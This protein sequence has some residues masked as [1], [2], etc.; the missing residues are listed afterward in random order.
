[1]GPNLLRKSRKSEER[2]LTGDSNKNSREGSSNRDLRWSRAPQ[3]ATEHDPC[4]H[5][6]S[7]TPTN[8]KERLFSSSERS[9]NLEVLTEKDGALDLRKI[10]RNA[11]VLQTK[12]RG[13][14]E[15]QG[16]QMGT[17]LGFKR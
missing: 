13:R 9:R 12:E 17:L 15:W 4:S 7:E 2:S 1:M 11:V 10:K 8:W 3:G 6:I 5:E 14:L 16:L